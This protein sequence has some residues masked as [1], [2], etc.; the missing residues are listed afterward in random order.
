MF[1]AHTLW[2]G[3]LSESDTFW[4]VNRYAQRVGQVWG[5]DVAGAMLDLTWGYPSLLRAVSEAYADG[6]GLELGEL[7]QHPAVR[8]RVDEFWNDGPAENDIRNVGLDGL[9]LLER[10]AHTDDFDTSR[11]TAKEAL[12]LEYLR[13]HPGEVCTKDDLVRAVWPEDQIYEYGVR[14][15]SLAQLVR[16]TRVKIEPDPSAPI[17]IH[18]VPGRGYRFTPRE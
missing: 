2:L 16:R 7:K 17:F 13:S 12:L 14:D 5:D 6:T 1:Y 10:T 4:N 9:P 3:P 18:T 11:L 15:D 8:R